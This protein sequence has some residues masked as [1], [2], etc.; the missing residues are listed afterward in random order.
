M[1]E[2]S[3]HIENSDGWFEDDPA[4]DANR[5]MRSLLLAKQLCDALENLECVKI[6]VVKEV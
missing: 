1:N 2:L 6:I 4:T 5:P 3:P